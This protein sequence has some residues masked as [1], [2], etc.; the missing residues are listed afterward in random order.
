MP[1]VTAASR[2]DVVETRARVVKGPP[3][4]VDRLMLYPVAVFTGSQVMETRKFPAS[5]VKRLGGAG[6]GTGVA[7]MRFEWALR[8]PAL[9]AWTT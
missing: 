3:G 7:E 8:P 1:F 5:A 4:L 2:Y 9:S 6:G